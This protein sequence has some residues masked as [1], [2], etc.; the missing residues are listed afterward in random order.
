VRPPWRKAVLSMGNSM[1][2]RNLVWNTA[3]LEVGTGGDL[4]DI[5]NTKEIKV[6]TSRMLRTTRNTV[7]TQADPFLFI[8]DG[9]LYLFVE[10]QRVNQYGEIE[11]WRTRDLESFEHLGVILSLPHHVSFPLVFRSDSGIHMLPETSV[12]SEVAIYTFDNFPFGLRKERILLKGKYYDSTIYR[13]DGLWW[14]LSTSSEGL[15]LFYISD[16]TSKLQKH[17]MG[18]ISRDPSNCRSGGSLIKWNGKLYRPAQNCTHAY[19]GNLG[20]M[21]IV[22]MTTDTY[23][24]VRARTDI[25]DYSVKWRSVGAHHLTFVSFNG[26]NVLAVDGQQPDYWINRPLSLA[27]RIFS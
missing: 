6:F 7:H 14:I 18:I 13:K 16:F 9:W 2:N 11:A 5:A 24:E 15:G 17:P 20:I 23:C 22:D 4:F 21:E 3:I 12:A 1:F 19:G 26:R 25:F 10:T 8:D 27:F